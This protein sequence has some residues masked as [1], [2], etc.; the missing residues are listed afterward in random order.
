M[1]PALNL[2]Y[3]H[4]A[5]MGYGRLGV[6][7]ATALEDVGVTVYDH[8]PGGDDPSGSHADTDRAE[9]CET[10]CWVSVPTHANGWWS[11]Q[12]AVMFTMW[13]A[14]VLPESFRETLDNIDLVVVPSM[15]NVELFSR[16]HRD[17]KYVPLGVDPLVWHFVKRTPPERQFRFLI[18]GSGRRKGTDVA[19]AAFQKVFGDWAG[20]GPE[21]VLVMK[22]PRGEDFYGDRV[23]M[24]SGKISA[25]DEVMLYASSHCYVQPSRGEGFGL[26][27]LQAIAQG[28]PT[29]LTGAHGHA[30]FSDLGMPLDYSMAK[31][32]YFIYGDA[33][34]WWEPDFD[35]L[36]EYMRFA[37]ENYD[38]CVEHAVEGAA[39]V[40][41]EFTWRRTAERFLDALGPDRLGTVSGPPGT[42]VKPA[43]K[44][45][46]IR[47]NRQFTADIAGVRHQWQ[48]GH[49]YWEHADVKRIL[50]EA[51]LLD[52]AC[53]DPHG[54]GLTADQVSRMDVYSSTH[55]FCYACG[56]HLGGETRTDIILAELEAQ[57]AR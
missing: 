47:V 25:A 48:P 14:S 38:E 12:R 5:S 57:A 35:Q 22:N 51:G 28:L 50:F 41:A 23:E 30:A 26:Q 44:L 9:V 34:D 45:F 6:N 37:Y 2:L 11:S 3:V 16:F 56:Q 10:A 39:T 19:F 40:A 4:A 15:Q 33:G 31:S 1:N 55:G 49:E 20:H 21:P 36:C 24:V 52:P 7:L 46:P 13:E 43:Q 53:I 27:P 18:G 17:V 29:I 8:L 32:D 54:Q 42:W